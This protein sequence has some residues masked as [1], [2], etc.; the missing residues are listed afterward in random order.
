MDLADSKI[1][2]L[3]EREKEK[4]NQKKIKKSKKS[5]KIIYIEN[6]SSFL[7]IINVLIKYILI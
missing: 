5:K 1:E 6:I 3:W 4:R 2:D 7:F